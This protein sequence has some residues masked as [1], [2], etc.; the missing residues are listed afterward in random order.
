MEKMKNSNIEWI[1]NIPQK[2]KEKRIKDIII[3]LPKSDIQAGDGE[4]EGKYWFYT[5][6]QELSKRIDKCLYD[7]DAIIMGTGGSASVNYSSELFSTSTDC[8]NFKTNQYTK[9]VF[10]WLYSIKDEVINE[11]WFEGMG[12]RHL[13]KNDILSSHIY[14]PKTEEQKMI[15]DFLENKIKKLDDILKDINNEIELLDKYKKSLITETVLKGLNKNRKLKKSNIE[16]IGDIPKDWTCKKIKNIITNDKNGIKVGPFG[17]SLKDI[18]VGENEG[19]YKI[20]GQANL[21]RKDFEYGDNFVTE[22]DYKRLINYEVLPNDIA[23]SMMGTIGK[24]CV[25]PKNIKKGIMDSHLIKIRLKDDI[26]PKY[27]EYQYESNAIYEQLLYF[28]NGSIMNGLNSTI[29]SNIYLTIPDIIEQQKIVDYLD[30]KCEEINV[31]IEDKKKQLEKMEQYKKS[32]IYEYV[33]G[34][35]RVKGAEELYG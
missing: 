32:L 8:F 28:S 25:V 9:F 21:I 6:S 19:K 34:K 30:R 29:V 33:T 26:V 12:L 1:G 20:Y 2:W 7:G 3:I 17:S 5:S 18:V 11:I 35:K 4:D 24:C 13:Q 10:C 14:L 16:W 22:K 15:A 31:L 23:V 27:F